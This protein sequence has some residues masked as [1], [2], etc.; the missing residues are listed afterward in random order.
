MVRHEAN[1]TDHQ[2]RNALGGQAADLEEDVRAQP[3]LLG[4]AGAL[5]RELVVRDAQPRRDERRGPG[6][7]RR[8]RVTLGHHAGGQRM[9]GEH[10]ADARRVGEAAVRLKGGLRQRLDEARLVMP[11]RHVVNEWG[12]AARRGDVRD[13]VVHGP[14][15]ARGV[16]GGLRRQ[17]DGHEPG[18]PIGH[19]ALDD[20]AD[21]RGD[22]AHAGIDRDL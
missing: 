8:V 10:V 2:A 1:G 20:V 18:H 21:A 3:R 13:G 9:G 7:L 17:G 4:P 19:H 22:V 15:V 5:E 6:Q 11:G 16:R 12:G 14:P